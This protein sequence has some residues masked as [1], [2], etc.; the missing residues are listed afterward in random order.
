MESVVSSS[1]CTS[2]V[3]RKEFEKWAY[4][5]SFIQI[6]VK[7]RTMRFRARLSLSA[8]MH[9][10]IMRMIFLLFPSMRELASIFISATICIRLHKMFGFPLGALLPFVFEDMRLPSKILPVVSID[11]GI[12]R[13]G[14]VTIRAPH[15]FEVEH[16]EI[17]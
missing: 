2:T 1:R 12:S 6:R 8:S 17:G 9:F 7:V 15:S 16:V 4:W 5:I 14:C 10:I 13:M 11:T 3:P